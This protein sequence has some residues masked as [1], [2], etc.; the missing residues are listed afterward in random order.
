MIKPALCKLQDAPFNSPDYW[1]EAKLDG[2]RIIAVIQG[3]KAKLFGRSGSEKTR[4]FPELRFQT[5]ADCVL[6]GEVLSGRCFNDMQHRVNRG[7]GIEQAAKEFPARYSVFDILQ[8]GDLSVAG[9]P[10]FKRKDILKSVVTETEN[11]ALT[12]YLQDGIALFD[13]M[14]THQLEGVVGKSIHGTYRENKRDWLKVKCWQD[15]EFIAVGYT[16]GTGWRA[17]TFGALVLSDAAGRYVGQVGTGF[18]EDD[19]SR[20]YASMKGSAGIAGCPWPREPEPATWVTPFP[21]KVRYLEKTS[22][23]QLRFPSFKGAV[24]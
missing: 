6:D 21:V 19:V 9:S 5:S 20:L 23:G 18:S 12:T 3:G 8:V 10:L 16:K 2:A 11:V 22:D 13:A 14:K 4:L 15:G 24:S 1:W 7:S 17:S